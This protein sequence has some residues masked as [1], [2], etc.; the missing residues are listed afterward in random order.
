MPVNIDAVTNVA[1]LVAVLV[2]AVWAIA[3]VTTTTAVL[4]SVV[5]R[6]EKQAMR[7]QYEQA[8]IERRV[9]HLEGALKSWKQDSP[10]PD[11]ADE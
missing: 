3:K 11:G 5:E 2:A 4:R 6:V 10:N 7:L 9:S 8:K 1:Q